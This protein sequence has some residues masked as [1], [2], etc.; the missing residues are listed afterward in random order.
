MALRTKLKPLMRIRP[1]DC[2][3][4]PRIL[5]WRRACSAGENDV[6]RTPMLPLGR[7]LIVRTDH[8][9]VML[10]TLPLAAALERTDA[11]CRVVCW[12]RR[13]M[14][15]S[16]THHPMLM[17][18]CSTRWKRRGPD[19]ADRGAHAASSGAGMLDRR[20]RHPTPRLALALLRPHFRPHRHGASVLLVPCWTGACTSIGG[21]RRGCTRVITI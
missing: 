12:R 5:Q 4:P 10:L 18:S 7:V 16:G 3:E 6:R 19:G 15:L 20:C 21:T 2:T 17:R 14:P 8:S 1:R 13:R 11:T 9:A